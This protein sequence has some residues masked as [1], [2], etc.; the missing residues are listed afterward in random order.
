MDRQTDWKEAH[1]CHTDFKTETLQA[2][3]WQGCLGYPDICSFWCLLCFES[4]TSNGLAVGWLQSLKT[5]R[6]NPPENLAILI[7]SGQ[8]P[9]TRT[10]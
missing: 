4:L 7:F 2:D 10:I 6:Q 9:C 3:K 8:K 1:F 5:L